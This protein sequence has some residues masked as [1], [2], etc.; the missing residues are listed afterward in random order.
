MDEKDFKIIE[1]P[2]ISSMS[3]VDIELSIDNVLSSNDLIKQLNDLVIEDEKERYV[4]ALLN[5]ISKAI[6]VL[7]DGVKFCEN[8]SQ[9]LYDKCNIAIAREKKVIDILK[10]Y[11]KYDKQI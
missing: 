10:G 2:G 6:T 5:R 11:D 4:R 1:V 7:E 8:D 9:G 3:D